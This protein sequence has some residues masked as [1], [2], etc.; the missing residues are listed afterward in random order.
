MQG[1]AIQICCT[2]S[3][4]VERHNERITIVDNKFDGL[5]NYGRQGVSIIEGRDILIQGN[6]FWRVA[7]K[8]MPGAI[9]IE[10]NPLDAK[11]ILRNI[12]VNN[13]TFRDIG[14]SV[15]DVCLVL[16]PASFING[17]PQGFLFEGN[18]HSGL[19]TAPAYYSNWVGHTAAASDVKASLTIKKNLIS[20]QVLAANHAVSVANLRGV[21]I[22]GN[23]ISGFGSGAGL[24]YGA[25][26]LTFSDN[27][28]SE[29]GD[30][31][32][33][34]LETDGGVLTD[35]SISRNTVYKRTGHALDTL[36]VC[37]GG[38]SSAITISDNVT[39]GVRSLFGSYDGHRTNRASNR[40]FGNIGA[41]LPTAFGS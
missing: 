32:R 5:G 28:I 7:S 8:A 12:T 24:F 29:C 34:A 40:A 21:T 17:A 25:M 19:T 2:S 18:L 41:T 13:N 39:T 16:T 9:D 31:T 36:I 26:D 35:V 3:A 33:T 10:P 6:H 23:S 38:S 4:A 1:D 15:G 22:T 30:L 14:G 20:S 27:T 11:S 37:G